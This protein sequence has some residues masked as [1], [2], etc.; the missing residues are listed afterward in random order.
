MASLDAHDESVG[1][2]PFG[3][4]ATAE[5]VTERLR[6]EILAGEFTPGQRLGQELLASRFNA[7]RMPVRTALRQLEAEGLVTTIAHSGAWVSKLDRFEFEQ[8][9]KMREALEPLA[10]AESLPH[11]SEGQVDEIVA[12]AEE[13]HEATLPRV[14]IEDFLRLDRKF[15]L[16]TYAGVRY[17]P[18]RQQVER[19]WNTTQHYRRALAN[20]LDDDRAQMTDH[21]HALIVDAVRRRDQESARALVRLHI[22][23]TRQT[24]SDSEEIFA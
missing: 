6:A 16:L 5:S 24:I 23:R 11:L 14:K 2:S 13:L 7:S 3:A 4:P 10:I 19:L 22:N 20:R 1:A 8:V 12:V 15:H 17:E 18:L 21:D 9:Y